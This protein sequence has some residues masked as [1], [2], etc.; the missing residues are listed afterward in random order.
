M[1]VYVKIAELLENLIP[2][3]RNIVTHNK[4]KFM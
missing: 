4:T 2:V 3:F 1:V